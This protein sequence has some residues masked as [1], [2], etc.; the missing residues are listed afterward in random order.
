VDTHSTARQVTDENMFA[1]LL[2]AGYLKLQL[3]TID[4]TKIKYPFLSIQTY[5]ANRKISQNR[6]GLGNGTFPAALLQYLA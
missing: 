3:H 2:H 6:S 1:S 4:G 5:I